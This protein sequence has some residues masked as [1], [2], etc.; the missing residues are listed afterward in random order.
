MA[1]KVR[2]KHYPETITKLPPTPPPNKHPILQDHSQTFWASSEG[3]E[4]WISEA[5]TRAKKGVLRVLKSGSAPAE[6]PLAHLFS[7]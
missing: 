7:L 3:I 6:S 4:E 1:C 2:I 5:E